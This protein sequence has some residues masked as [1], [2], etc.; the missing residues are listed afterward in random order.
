MGSPDAV[1]EPTLTEANA[2]AAFT[3][4]AARVPDEPPPDEACDGT[5]VIIPGGGERYLPGAWLTTAL[6]RRL[7]CALPIEIWYMGAAEMPDRWRALLERLGA[8][9]VDA[10]ALRARHPTRWLGGFELKAYALLHARFRHVLL[11]DADNVPVHDP[12]FLFETEQYVT[13]G[14]IFWPDYGMGRPWLPIGA[15]SRSHPIWELTGVPYRGDREFESGQVCVDRRRCYREL[16]LADWLN[17]RSDFWYRYL[18]GDKDTFHL[19]W[20]KL[21]REWA[22]PARDPTDLSGMAMAQ[23]D[24]DGR[25][26]FLHRNGAKWSLGT[27]PRVPGF[28]HEDLCFELLDELRAALG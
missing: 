15:L 14:A 4:A 18:W 19:A 8:S 1:R 13:G 24:F 6:L 17:Q 27:N 3:D 12:S 22:M 16:A 10:L 11:L 21:Q 9:T 25:I 28:T 7:G 26:V 2:R 23:C 5:G 20:R